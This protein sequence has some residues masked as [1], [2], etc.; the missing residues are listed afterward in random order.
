MFYSAALH[1]SALKFHFVCRNLPHKQHKAREDVFFLSRKNII[2]GIFLKLR[3]GLDEMSVLFFKSHRLNQICFA[4][5]ET[6]EQKRFEVS[7]MQEV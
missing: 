4:H 5:D 3:N 7:I 6:I 1:A 2:G